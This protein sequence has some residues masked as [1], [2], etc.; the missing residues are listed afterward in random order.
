[1]DEIDGVAADPTDQEVQ[2]HSTSVVGSSGLMHFKQ[3]AVKNVF[4]MRM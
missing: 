2:Q 3:S 1:M 4:I